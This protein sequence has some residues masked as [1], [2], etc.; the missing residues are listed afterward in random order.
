VQGT[1]LLYRGVG[2][3]TEVSALVGF[4]GPQAFC[5]LFGRYTGFSPRQAFDME[6]R[7]RV[8]EGFKLTFNVCTDAVA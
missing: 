8:L 3:V 4:N 2:N 1:E 5:N 6:V 7:S